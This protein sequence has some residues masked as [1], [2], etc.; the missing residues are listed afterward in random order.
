MDKFCK[1]N[2]SGLKSQEHSFFKTIVIFNK[3][4][5]KPIQRDIK[6]I[7]VE[8]K[9]LL[10]RLWHEDTKNVLNLYL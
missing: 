4:L 3:L 1:V 8:N 5:A 2:A 7:R 10:H 9:F 6:Q